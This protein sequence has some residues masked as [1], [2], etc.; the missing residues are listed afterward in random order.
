MV[1]I[2]VKL[3]IVLVAAALMLIAGNAAVDQKNQPPSNPSCIKNCL[4]KCRSAPNPN[5]C[6]RDC[7]PTCYPPSKAHFSDCKINCE[8]S[9]CNKFASGNINTNYFY[10]I[11]RFINLTGEM[12]CSLRRIHLLWSRSL[13]CLSRNYYSSSRLIHLFDASDDEKLKGCKVSCWQNCNA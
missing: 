7:Y 2:N 1:G 3:A 6:L 13:F 5:E 9:A 8:K 10:R 11:V 12:S 4:G